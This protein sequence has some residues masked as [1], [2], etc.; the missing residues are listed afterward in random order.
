[1]RTS[2]RPK[3]CHKLWACL[4]TDT[5]VCPYSWTTYRNFCYKLQY[6][7]TTWQ[8]A[9][10]D[11]QSL[12]GDL[13]RITSSSLRFQVY[14][15]VQYA[16]RQN[17]DRTSKWWIGLN[18]LRT[19]NQWMWADNSTL[20]PHIIQW[21]S[22][23]PPTRNPG[24]C[25]GIL[26]S[27]FWDQ[28]CNTKSPYICE[29]PKSLPLTCASNKQ[30]HTLNG[31]CYKFY[32]T[33]GAWA[34]A[35]RRCESEH[36]QLLKVDSMA[37]EK[38]LLEYSASSKRDMWIGLHSS[39][40]RTNTTAVWTW[41]DGSPLSPAPRFWKRSPQ[42]SRNNL[43]TTCVFVS[44]LEKNVNQ[45]WQTA[46]CTGAPYNRGM[47][48][49][50]PE[51][52]CVTG[53][54]IDQIDDVCL[55]INSR[56]KM[57]WSDANNYCKRQG[58]SLLFYDSTNLPL[59]VSPLMRTME[60]SGV[61]SFWIGL[62]DNNKDGKPFVWADGRTVSSYFR[63]RYFLPVN[64]TNTR[65]KQDCGYQLTGDTGGKWRF[66]SNCLEQRAF[67]CSIPIDEPVQSALTTSPPL[68]CPRGWRKFRTSCYQVNNPTKNWLD[69]RKAC[70]AQG[71]DLARVADSRAQSV[72]SGW[73]RNK[74]VWIGLNDRHN[75]S[76]WVWL[77]DTKAI[78][79]TNWGP[80]E[81]N[82]HGSENCGEIAQRGYWTDYPCKLPLQYICEKTAD[83]YS[84]TVPVT[85][86]F[87]VSAKCGMFW[88]DM[89]NS[90]YC[91]QFNEEQ[92]DWS[93]A[94]STCISNGGDLVS[95]VNNQEQAYLIGHLQTMSSLAVWTGANDQAVEAGWRWSDQQPYAFLNWVAGEPGANK[96]NHD[97]AVMFAQNNIG[98]WDDVDCTVRYGFICKKMGAIS[99]TPQTIV[100]TPR[101]PA[102]MVYGCPLSWVPHNGNCYRSISRSGSWLS[103]RTACRHIG[104]DLATILSRGD[105]QFVYSQL[106]RGPARGYW[107]GL[108]DRQIRMTFQWTSGAKVT[109]TTWDGT[110]PN[111]FVDG[112]QNCVYM[113]TNRRGRWRDVDCT[114]S[115]K[116]FV[117]QR[118]QGPVPVSQT[119]LNTGCTN[120][121]AIALGYRYSCYM[122]GT[123]QVMTWQ[124]AE[125]YCVQQFSGHLATVN[126]MHTQSY[127]ASFL[128]HH[129]G[130]YWIGLSDTSGNGTTYSWTSGK[131]IS[132]TGW[133][134]THTG[135][136]TNMCVAMRGGVPTGLWETKPC[137]QIYQFI[138]EAGRPGYTPPPTT[139]TA[140]PTKPP[141]CDSGWEQ[142][143]GYCYQSFIEF[144]TD[145]KS[146]FEA[147]AICHNY[148]GDLVSIQ[149]ADEDRF[150]LSDVLV[151]WR[152]T[153]YW[154]GLNNISS[155]EGMEWPDGIPYT[156]QKWDDGEP[157]SWNG[158]EDCVVYDM[159]ARKWKDMNCHLAHNYICKVQLGVKPTATVPAPTLGTVIPC[160]G[161]TT[162]WKFYNGYCYYV[163]DGYGAESQMSWY[164]AREYCL[165]HGGDLLSLHSQM[166]DNF[167]TSQIAR[168]TTTIYWIGLN[169][170]MQNGYKWSDLTVFD[171][172][173]W[174][175]NE[176]ND[177]YGGQRCVNLYSFSTFWND[178]N[179]GESHGFICKRRN[180]STAPV[181]IPPTPVSVWG[182]N[183][184]FTPVPNHN[185]CFKVMDD[186][187][188][189]W[190]DAVDR[191]RQYGK[192][193]DVASVNTAIE[194]A[195]LITLMKGKVDDYWI[196]LSARTYLRVYQWQDNSPVKFVNWATGKPGYTWSAKC[197]S[198]AS[199]AETVGQWTNTDC[200]QTKRLVCQGFREFLQPTQSPNINNCVNGYQSYG[201]SCYKLVTS[202]S[203][204]WTSAQSNCLQEGGN[205]VSVNDI[206]EQS[207]LT[208]LTENS[209]VWLGLF[210]T[211][212]AGSYGWI[213]GWPVTFTYWDDDEPSSG[214]NNGCVAMF[215]SRWDDI[216]CSKNLSYVCEISTVSPPPTTVPP[217]GWCA[218]SKWTRQGDYCY[219]VDTSISVPWH[220]ADYLCKKKGMQL[221]SIMNIEEA[222][223]VKDL[224]A[225]T[226][227]STNTFSRSNTGIWIGLTKTIIG[228]YTWTD[229]NPV[230][231]LHW[232]KGEPTGSWDGEDEE[233]VEIV[234]TGT[235][236]DERCLKQQG[237]ICKDNIVMPTTTTIPTTTTTVTFGTVTGANCRNNIPTCA[238]YGESVCHISDYKAWVLDNCAEYCGMCPGVT[239]TVT[240][241]TCGDTLPNCATFGRK[242]CGE[243]QQWAFDSCRRYCGFCP[244]S[245]SGVQSTTPYMI[246]ADIIDDCEAYGKTACEAPYIEWAKETCPHYCG[247]CKEEVITHAVCKDRI[248]NC[249]ETNHNA[250]VKYRDWANANCAEY[251]GLCKPAVLTTTTMKKK[252]VTTTRATTPRS[253][254]T[255]STTTRATT[256]RQTTT[257][258]TTTRSTAVHTSMTSK[259]VTLPFTPS[260]QQGNDNSNKLPGG[261]I[262]GIV[263][264]VLVIAVVVVF[265]V[266]FIRRNTRASTTEGFDNQ[267]YGPS[268]EISE[269]SLDDK[270]IA[271]QRDSKD[272]Y[273]ADA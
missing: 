101:L 28:S 97:C 71:A 160:A 196:G 84:T 206:Y 151:S 50:K 115:Q 150:L 125:N 47:V 245:G 175:E 77:D 136:E 237:Y 187:A 117:C 213:D 88:E 36:S 33:G 93:D 41:S 181:I 10:Q 95:I 8:A 98:K 27:K 183:H 61:N 269:T 37:D 209:Y 76:T 94:R 236:N 148:G 116:G 208:I 223:F 170:L 227:T 29:R 1:M 158:M 106:P 238:Q 233:C 20:L 225:K 166:E 180:D 199:A 239:Q 253:T 247:F 72:I 64:G 161:N 70:Q 127:L 2:N 222:V 13:A 44:H 130:Y 69:A 218:D 164:D 113:A 193:Y 43:D 119:V 129:I 111:G 264:A 85:T 268:N 133:Y 19:L 172:E 17:A 254:T 138:C 99:T 15:M 68:R 147:R 261:A 108:S 26:N 24:R 14:R 144:N 192:H 163:S 105:Q 173:N 168:K 228:S 81:P 30:W 134:Q 258:A 200:D 197:V 142:Y 255:R 132:Y 89:P 273:Q 131:N 211:Q 195:Y 120:M 256:S 109:F 66:T 217:P 146:W 65:G 34:T 118:G 232:T 38:I 11:C 137:N 102:G 49:K 270:F 214:D 126:D 4:G 246:C 251:C 271:P 224:I 114:T 189:N 79:Y 92:L 153:Q 91:Y 110:E 212:T 215:N 260:K 179:C 21:Q 67:I 82:S 58:A 145:K 60:L 9:R 241:P 52:T 80:G 185:K 124:N 188:M 177:A 87:A 226:D 63:R 51:G 55:Q 272:Y 184:G 242:A 220:S 107:I 243:Y 205:L 40:D 59:F 249:K 48:C 141:T 73:V 123:G 31:N 96:N 263:I 35:K 32:R 203:T 182:C 39:A 7:K 210:D 122:V 167:I 194:Q 74:F 229:N 159:P 16:G 103:A 86:P 257:R 23:H 6:K 266:I 186:S 75:E 248:P 83:S 171:H 100:T 149:D 250:C 201:Q 231:F 262:A 56:Y 90:P 191:C 42:V 62:T 22:R 162:D 244:N 154:I 112:V 240:V 198:M 156:Y 12:S 155:T 230:T 121:S 234:K 219:F 202:T 207:F 174:A 3:T 204:N 57:S 128:N 235:W 5:Q 78:T 18:D 252:F 46:S 140:K 178:D 45:A 265:G 169:E 54:K 267:L 143:K 152:A 221:A 135:K 104:G 259:P 176:P 139:T 216:S 25:V 53:W 157:N 165:Q 190:T